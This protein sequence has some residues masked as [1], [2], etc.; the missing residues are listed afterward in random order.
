MPPHL[1][2][3][4]RRPSLPSSPP[5]LLINL[6]CNL[7]PW[8]WLDQASCVMTTGTFVPL[9]H[10]SWL[11]LQWLVIANIPERPVRVTISKVCHA[12][13]TDIIRL[14]LQTFPPLRRD[15][16]C[17]N[18]PSQDTLAF[19]RGRRTDI[20]GERGRCGRRSCEGHGLWYNGGAMD[21]GAVKRN[22]VDQSM[23]EEDTLK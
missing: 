9:R 11:V 14:L 13:N 23:V 21:E 1:G 5:D 16:A 19:W 4:S 22:V 6:F 2:N 10:P 12:V 15:Y 3:C 18:H 8:S 20:E 7:K 17:L